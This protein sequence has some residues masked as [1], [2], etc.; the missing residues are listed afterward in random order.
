MVIIVSNKECGYADM[1]EQFAALL[2]FSGLTSEK[3][4]TGLEG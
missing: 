1:A 4:G 3:M 2:V